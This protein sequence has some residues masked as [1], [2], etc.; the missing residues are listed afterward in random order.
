MNPL[1]RFFAHLASKLGAPAGALFFLIFGCGQK[2]PTVPQGQTPVL[3]SA[4]AENSSGGFIKKQTGKHLEAPDAGLE[5][6]GVDTVA[7]EPDSL[8]YATAETGETVEK[9][10][11]PSGYTIKFPIGTKD[12][13]LLI[14]PDGALDQN[15]NLS[16]RANLVP[17][18]DEK[19]SVALY[20]FSPDGLVYLKDCYLVQPTRFPDGTLLVLSWFNPASGK[21]EEES[22]A[23]VQNGRAVFVIKH[24]S[25]YGAPYDGDGL[26]SGGQ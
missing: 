16:L 10:V 11:G 15:W 20:D 23:R 1:R 3:S 5:E 12:T 9:S 17:T 19:M 4:A 21:W 18:R 24:F 14:V 13:A 26:G 8:D 22:V 6:L 25:T 2:L 7:F